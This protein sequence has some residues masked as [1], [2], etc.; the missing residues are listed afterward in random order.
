MKIK[1]SVEAE[2]AEVDLLFDMPVGCLKIKYP[3]AET[4]ER[5]LADT[6]TAFTMALNEMLR[7]AFKRGKKIGKKFADEKDTEMY[8]D[9][10]MS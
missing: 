7:E 10:P 5:A 4:E 3:N 9:K 8:S 6:K 2:Q 1:H